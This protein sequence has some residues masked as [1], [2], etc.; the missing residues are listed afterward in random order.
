MSGTEDELVALFEFGFEIT[1]GVGL[2]VAWW[3][4][5]WQSSWLVVKIPKV[6]K[7]LLAIKTV[8]WFTNFPLSL[9]PHLL[10]YRRMKPP[11][12][13]VNDLKMAK[14]T[15]TKQL[16]KREGRREKASVSVC[17][18]VWANGNEIQKRTKGERAIAVCIVS[19]QS[20]PGRRKRREKRHETRPESDQQK[21]IS[22]NKL[23]R[24]N[25]GT[26]VDYPL[27]LHFLLLLRL[28]LL[29]VSLNAVVAQAEREKLEMRWDGN[30][31][32]FH[33]LLMS[34][35]ES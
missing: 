35:S 24:I 2:D 12:T 32:S 30:E 17:C 9:A 6:W 33:Q 22:N 16:I 14:S 10:H 15:W 19:N 18:D 5:A 34:R 1:F 13:N 29:I 31:K 3:W 20:W 23:L 25:G 11:R 27:F 21:N 7:V 4:V 26:V 28:R 8:T